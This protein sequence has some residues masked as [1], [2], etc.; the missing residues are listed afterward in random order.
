[1]TYANGSNDLLLANF[2]HIKLIGY[3]KFAV[4]T[5]VVMYE[6]HY[7]HFCIYIEIQYWCIDDKYRIYVAR[8]RNGG[9]TSF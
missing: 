7:R 4:V 3:T 6:E 1:M 5:I 9:K 2:F 8:L